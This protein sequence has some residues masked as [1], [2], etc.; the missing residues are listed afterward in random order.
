MG[1]RRKKQEEQE[2]E[3]SRDGAL[4][5]SFCLSSGL[6]LSFPLA[7]RLFPVPA[8]TPNTRCPTNAFRAN[9]VI[10]SALPLPGGKLAV[11]AGMIPTAARSGARDSA[12]RAASARC[13]T[14]SVMPCSVAAAVSV[15]ASL[16]NPLGFDVLAAWW[17]ALDRR[18][19]RFSMAKE[20][21]RSMIACRIDKTGGH[22]VSMEY[23]KCYERE[24]GETES[25]VFFRTTIISANR[26]GSEWCLSVCPSERLLLARP[27]RRDRPTRKTSRQGTNSR[28]EM[29]QQTLAH[30]LSQAHVPRA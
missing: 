14:G 22:R 30:Q 17:L 10:S 25:F 12:G 21:Q 1:G 23:A 9:P 8:R 3:S 28:N 26:G 13:T 24:K 18:S 29:Q 11:R 5:C 7:T 27:T 6:L 16:T 4:S 2:R 20:R 19:P 15:D